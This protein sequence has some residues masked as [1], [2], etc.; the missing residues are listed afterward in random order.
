MPGDGVVVDASLVVDF[1]VGGSRAA[2]IA[3]RIAG[4]QLVAPAHIDAEILSA[5]GRLHRAGGASARQ[6]ADRLAVVLRLP[7]RRELLDG[8]VLG[9]WRRRENLRL[10]DALYVE[11]AE[12]EGLP[13]LTTDAPLA[14]AARVAELVQ[15]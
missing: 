10:A 6:V 2:L 15:P 3:E 13:L 1:V 12:R 14:R 7:I 9:A 4:H 5:F 11:L 8:L